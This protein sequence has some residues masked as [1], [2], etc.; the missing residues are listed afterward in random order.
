MKD[1]AYKYRFILLEV[2][3]DTTRATQTLKIGYETP[4]FTPK[5]SVNRS[6]PTEGCLVVMGLG[7]SMDKLGEPGRGWNY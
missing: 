2:S 7:C 6:R 1:R 4:H 3:I 5:Q